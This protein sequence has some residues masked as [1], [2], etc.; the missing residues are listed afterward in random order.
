VFHLVSFH[1]TIIYYTTSHFMHPQYGRSSLCCAVFLLVCCL[2]VCCLHA[3]LLVYLRLLTSLL[4]GLDNALV[5]LCVWNAASKHHAPDLALVMFEGL[6]LLFFH[7]VLF[8][9]TVIYHITFNFM[10]P[11]YDRSLLCSAVV[12]IVIVATTT[13]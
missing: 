8:H 10:H 13:N 4:D 5:F 2:L 12:V 3:C 6:L 1:F 9:I 11:Q 7:L